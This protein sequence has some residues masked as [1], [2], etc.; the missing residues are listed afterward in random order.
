MIIYFEMHVFLF[1]IL[2]SDCRK[3]IQ[4]YTY[5][6]VKLEREPGSISCKVYGNWQLLAIKK[7]RSGRK[8]AVMVKL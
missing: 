6:K 3:H 4:A 2:N 1:Q 8:V 5:M 7:R